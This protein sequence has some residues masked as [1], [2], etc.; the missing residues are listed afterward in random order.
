MI[1]AP[2]ARRQRDFPV[3]LIV[4]DE[5]AESRFWGHPVI[6]V[7]VRL[8]ALLPHI[9]W[10][11]FLAV[12][13]LLWMV[14]I[15]WI[16]ILI[17]RR[18]P[19]FQAEIYEDL[20]HRGSRITAYLLLLPGYPP[21]GI[22]APGPVDVWFELDGLSMSRWWGIPVIGPLA[23]LVAL[24]PHFIVLLVL[25]LIVAAV[26][27]FV[28]IPIFVNARIPNVAVR[29]FGAYLR[30]AARVASYAFLLPVPYPPFSLR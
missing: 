21:L 30:Y 27:L 13:G 18:V 16:P 11:A 9:L 2:V 20:I 5:R 26:W 6:G 23:R 8:V 1:E 17:T 14:L 12:V 29:I 19:S 4:F 7:L 28:W 22:G 24:I 10:W 3:R 25:G 15:G